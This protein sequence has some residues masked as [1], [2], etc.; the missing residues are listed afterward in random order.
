MRSK[1]FVHHL[2]VKVFFNHYKFFKVFKE[3]HVIGEK[4]QLC[5]SCKCSDNYHVAS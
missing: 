1:T 3:A 5:S 4:D 2:I